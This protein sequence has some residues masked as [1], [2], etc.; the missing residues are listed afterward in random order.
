MGH[1]FNGHGCNEDMG[2]PFDEP[3]HE[4]NHMVRLFIVRGD[5]FGV[6]VEAIILVDMATDVGVNLALEVQGLLFEMI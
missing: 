3:L 4:L 2:L 6:F 1:F 5:E